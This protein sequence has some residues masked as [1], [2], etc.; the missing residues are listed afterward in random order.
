MVVSMATR[1]PL[2]G[3]MGMGSFARNAN[4]QMAT[5]CTILI[6]STAITRQNPNRA[7]NSQPLPSPVTPGPGTC[8]GSSSQPMKTMSAR[9]VAAVTAVS[10]T[11]SPR[12]STEWNPTSRRGLASGPQ[13]RAARS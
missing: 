5:A 13:P 6:V 11:L 4:T 12:C 7:R 1:S 8:S 10:V 9:A 2:G 3:T